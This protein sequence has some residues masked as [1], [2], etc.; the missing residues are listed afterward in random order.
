MNH[1]SAIQVVYI[2]YLFSLKEVVL[3]WSERVLSWI[4]AFFF[5]VCNLKRN[6][7]LLCHKCP[8]PIS[9][10]QERIRTG[11][12]S[13]LRKIRNQVKFTASTKNSNTHCACCIEI[14]IL[15]MLLC[16]HV[17]SVLFLVWFNNFALTSIGVTRSYSTCLHSC[18]ITFNITLHVCANFSHGEHWCPSWC[19]CS[20]TRHTTSEKTKSTKLNGPIRNDKILLA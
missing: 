11:D 20:S 18:P 13:K 3:R 9:P 16:A 12:L 14:A 5:F 7:K 8:I 10:I 4:P 17:T 15:L 19:W 1:C 2:C 6:S